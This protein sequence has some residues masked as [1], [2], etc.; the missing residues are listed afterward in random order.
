MN[1]RDPNEGMAGDTFKTITFSMTGSPLTGLRAV[2][3]KNGDPNTTG[4]CASMTPGTAVAISDFNS[5][6]WDGSGTS[7]TDA[8]VP[9]IDKVGVQVSSSAAAATV[10]NLCL[11]KIAFGN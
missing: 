6:C 9:S 11:T 5:A 10:S 1:A 2:L 7:L 3:H 4:Y 8:D